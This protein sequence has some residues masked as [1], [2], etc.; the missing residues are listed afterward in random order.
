MHHGQTMHVRYTL[1]RRPDDDC[2]HIT[3]IRSPL[4]RNLTNKFDELRDEIVE[5]FKEYIPLTE[6]KPQRVL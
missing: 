6:G 5:A 1:G 3:T 2:Y 4:T